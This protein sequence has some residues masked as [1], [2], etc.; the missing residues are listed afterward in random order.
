MSLILKV[1][2][3]HDGHTANKKRISKRSSVSV[4]CVVK[5]VRLRLFFIFEATKSNEVVGVLHLFGFV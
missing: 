1:T 4:F 3:A 5:Y 2:W